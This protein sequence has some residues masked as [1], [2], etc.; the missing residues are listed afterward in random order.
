M[1]EIKAM[2]FDFDGVIVN[3]LK[4][5]F[6]VFRRIGKRF[7]KEPYATIE[8]HAI[9]WPGWKKKFAEWGLAGKDFENAHQMYIDVFKE[10]EDL[11]EFFSEIE[12][13]L[14][15]LREK[16]VKVGISSNN[17]KEVVE[18]YLKKYKIRDLVDDFVGGDEITHLKPNPEMILVCLK[19][20]GVLPQ[21]SAYVGDMCDDITAGKNAGTKTVAVTWGWQPKEMLEK[22]RPDLIA[23]TPIDIL[24]ILGM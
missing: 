6:E 7:N 18:T 13:V 10:L 14:K 19:K 8:E 11:I 24:K 1:S 2:V 21:N 22:C 4:A 17:Q 12:T 9:K 15:T 23:E 3:T 20:L 16:G 5:H